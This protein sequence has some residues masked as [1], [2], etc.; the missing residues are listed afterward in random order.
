M[1]KVLWVRFLFYLLFVF[2]LCIYSVCRVFGIKLVFKNLGEG[3]KK[4]E[5]VVKLC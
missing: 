5:E 3:G 2:L 4:R 1:N